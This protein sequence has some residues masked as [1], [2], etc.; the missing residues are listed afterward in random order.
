MS[1]RDANLMWIRDMLEHLSENRQRLE[2]TKDR[3]TVRVLTQAMLRDL[4]HCHR[5]CQALHERGADLA[6]A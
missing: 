1:H 4:E 2:W 3:E 5:L 6:A